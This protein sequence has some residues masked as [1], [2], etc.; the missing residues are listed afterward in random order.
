MKVSLLLGSLF[1]LGTATFLD[2]QGEPQGTIKA[3]TKLRPDGS[4]ATTIVDPDKRTAEETVTD[5]GGHIMKK[6]LFLLD[7]RNFAHAAIH[8]DAKGNIR[9]KENYKRDGSDRISEAIL[10]SKDDAP[11]G[12]RVFQYDTR[13]RAEIQD[14]D[15]SGNLIVRPQSAKPGRSDKRRR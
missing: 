1:F 14:Y 11:L 15:A 9:Y 7:D 8:Y 2:A 4:R 13:G 12:R 10:F 3:T 6:T 5:S